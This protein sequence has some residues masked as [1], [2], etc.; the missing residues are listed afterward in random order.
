[1]NLNFAIYEKAKYIMIAMMGLTPSDEEEER[2][3]ILSALSNN[4]NVEGY[5][6][7]HLETE[8]TFYLIEKQFYEAWTMNVGFVDDKSYIIK[9]EMIDVIDNASLVE[10]MHDLRLKDEISYGENFIF[11]P[12]FVF[13]PLSKWYKLTKVIERK[14]INYKADKK[15]ALNLFKQRKSV[16]GSMIIAGSS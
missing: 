6:Q 11:V 4:H 13:Y 12:K 16:T 15:R 1:M 2:E 8:D 9:K 10:P 5:I 14:V 3:S 7:E